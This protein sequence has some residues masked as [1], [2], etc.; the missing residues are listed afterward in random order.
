MFFRRLLE[1]VT[2]KPV[3]WVATGSIIDRAVQPPGTATENGLKLEISNIVLMIGCMI[4]LWHSLGLPY[5]YLGRNGIVS[6]CGY[7]A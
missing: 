5:K 4:L 7:V 3:F 6:L 2:R 1:L